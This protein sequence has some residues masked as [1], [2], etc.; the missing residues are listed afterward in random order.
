ME[1][2]AFA[3]G[4]WFKEGWAVIKAPTQN[5]S[6]HRSRVEGEEEVESSYDYVVAWRRLRQK[7]CE[8]KVVS[9]FDSRR[10]KPGRPKALP[11]AGGRGK[12]LKGN[13]WNVKNLMQLTEKNW[14]EWSN[15]RC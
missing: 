12:C 13:V 7:I 10:H 3:Q 9:D 1:P 2:E 8:V 4:R 11:G 15:W 5:L 6:I 14:T